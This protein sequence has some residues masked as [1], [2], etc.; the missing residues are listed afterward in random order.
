MNIHFKDISD[1]AEKFINILPEDWQAQLHT[2]PKA[3]IK[4]SKT[5]ILESDTGILAGGLIFSKILPEMAGYRDEAV[6]WYTSNYL[7]IGYLWVPKEYRN[8][9]MGSKWLSELK[10]RYPEQKFWL[11]IEDYNLKFF[12]EKNQFRFI[13]KLDIEK[14]DE[15]L[16]VYDFN[17][18][19]KL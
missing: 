18:Q 1:S 19:K 9:K 13:K 14:S 8:L 12:Y 2:I 16:M 4:S 3:I 5:F 17:E 10:S 6:H 15:W 11:T 7:Y